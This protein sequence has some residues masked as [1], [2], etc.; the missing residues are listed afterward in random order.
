MPH[1]DASLNV[2]L[3]WHQQVIREKCV[4]PTGTFIGF[5]QEEIEQSIP[6]RFEHQVRRYP[7]R[8]AVKTQ[9]QEL[10][11]DELN[12]TANR[13]AHAIL[14]QRG[15]GE[16]TTLLLLEQGVSEIAAIFGGLKAGKTYASL[17]PSYPLA[18]LNYLLEDSQTRLIVTNNQNLSL[19]RKLAQNKCQLLNID[20][21]DASVSSE[22][23]DL[24][25]APD[26]L[27]YIQY[28]SGST[29]QPKGATQAHRNL[30]HDIM[31]YTNAIHI[32][33]E[34]RMSLLVSGTNQ[35]SK[36][37]FG[38]LLN[39]A[40]LL[41]FNLKEEGVGRLAN[42]L[43]Q[44]D[45]TVC[46][47]AAMA[48]RNF[49]GTLTGKEVFPKLRVIR[50]ASE[51]VSKRDV[52][53]YK[54][55]FSS[56]CILING[57]SSSE[58]LGI[59]KYFIDKD[60]E[61]IT[62]TVPIGYPLEDQ[63]VLL[64][65]DEGQEVACNQVGEIVVKSRYLSPGYWCRPDLTRDKFLPD[66]DG[67]DKRVYRMGDLGRMLPDG[68]LEHLGRKDFMV[69]I[70]GHNVDVTEVEIALLNLA[71][72]EQ[73]VVM[74]R[75]DH[76]GNSQLVAYLVVNSQRP[77]IT[78]LHTFLT[79]QFP[80]H[81]IPAS[82]MFLEALPL[83]PSGKVDRSALP[84]PERTRP[85]L[86]YPYVAPRTPVEAELTQSWAKVLGRAPIGVWDNFFELGGDS[87]LAV[88]LVH[89]IEKG[90]GKTLPIIA[91]FSAPTVEGLAQALR[92]EEPSREW[93]SVMPLQ[94]HGL[95]PP[96]FFLAGRSHFGA[97]LGPDQPV[98]RVV[99]Q[100]LDREQPLVRVEAMAAHSIQSMRRVQ[101]DGPY[102]LG[103]HGFGGLVAF[104]IA[105]QLQRQGE[106]VALLTLCESRGPDSRR[107]TPGP[108]SAYRLW[109]RARYY[110][111]RAWHT[112]ARQ[113]LAALL[114]SLKNKTQRA[115][116]RR[117]GGPRTRSQQGYRAAI[118]DSRSHYVPQAYPGRITVV[119][120][121]ERAP[122]RDDDPLNGWGRL[123]T[124]GVEAYEVPGSHTS[125][126]REPNVE[127]L[128][129]TL[130]DVLRKAQTRAESE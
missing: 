115:A 35:A 62:D 25:L 65:N 96:F 114:R 130:N 81:M 17:V 100:D 10:T 24:A 82:F 39:G 9:N 58:T 121:T 84:E 107:S 123:A 46:R 26:R 12:K 76:H 48:F 7:D 80:D 108:S 34:D 3:P 59:R 83:L 56:D 124:D 13:V 71:T 5:K 94:P 60:T 88:Q 126:Y 4:H 36:V 28:T 67:E 72:V 33:P 29:G 1:T 102:Y 119:R 111:E 21:L 54:K 61:I 64:L 23:P 110:C 93:T 32:C 105:H 11:Y 8:L 66:P 43:I 97:R 99:Y 6:A 101:P 118:D 86:G 103:G 44:E 14:A 51:T 38:A 47:I 106:K 52:E 120:C 70:R 122:W 15:G 90:F 113:E 50:L 55:H 87:L 2:K 77:T 42:W 40:A 74:A 78:A 73:A 18:R 85:H 22:N 68:C 30:L 31:N 91:L 79:T 109:Q 98:Y 95:K 104:E 125:I 49:V 19:A 129:R 112:G 69:Q 117:Q 116:G 89:Q 16:E 41:P 57:L 63:E 92:E 75:E 128:A 53:L 127:V 20:A 27:A 45:I 37:I